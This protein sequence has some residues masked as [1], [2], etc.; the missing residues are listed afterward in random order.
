[1]GSVTRVGASVGMEV[2]FDVRAVSS[3]PRPE[4]IGMGVGRVRN[5]GER[6]FRLV[7]RATSAR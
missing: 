6:I 1:M 2:A 3:H 4:R 5:D 7:E